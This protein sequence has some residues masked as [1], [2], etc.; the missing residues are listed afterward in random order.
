M[1][2]PLIARLAAVAAVAAGTLVVAPSTA[3]ASAIHPFPYLCTSESSSD[4]HFTPGSE[5]STGTAV[6]METTDDY[7]T[8]E[9][10]N[11]SDGNLVI[12]SEGGQAIWASN[13]D[14]QATTIG[15][16]EFNGNFEVVRSTGPEL[17]STNTAV[18]TDAYICFQRDGNFVVYAAGGSCSGTALWASGT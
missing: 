6:C 2:L 4:Y 16:M 8:Y 14:V 7:L 18:H 3:D 15:V 5:I 12:Y 10:V 1:K 17:W 11:Q 9:L 13:T